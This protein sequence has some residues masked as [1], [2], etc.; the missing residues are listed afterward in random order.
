VHPKYGKFQVKKKRS[1]LPNLR[2]LDLPEIT[3]NRNETV[4]DGS[5]RMFPFWEKL[6]LSPISIQKNVRYFVIYPQ[7]TDIERSVLHFFKDL[8][9]M[10]EVCHLGIHR[11]GKADNYKNGLVPVPLMGKIEIDIFS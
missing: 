8:S 5:V 2:R 10:Y 3:V 9:A 1:T 4:L 6:G 11:P 7:N